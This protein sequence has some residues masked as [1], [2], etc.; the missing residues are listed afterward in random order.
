[1]QLGISITSAHPDADPAEGARRIIERARAA[2]AAELDSLSLGDH[3]ATAYPYFQGTPMLGR[4][5]ADWPADRPMGCLFLLPLWNPVLVAEQVGTLAALSDRPFV[6]QTGIGGGDQQFA[7][8]GSSPA[9]RGRD[10]DEAIRV[11]KALSAGETVT[12]ERFG[13]TDAVTAPRPPHGLEWWIGAGAPAAI[14]RAAREGDAWYAGPGV[15]AE[16]GAGMLDTYR[17]AC[18]RHD[19][20]PRAI[21]R[22]DLIVLDDGDRAARLG[23][24]LIASG[25]RGMQR[26]EVVCG[27]VDHVS[28]E[29][30]RLRSLG[31]DQV[32]IR[33]M[34]GIT[35][36]EAIETIERCGEVR[37]ALG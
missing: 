19:R 18:E 1:M 26:H 34:M 36:A 16:V 7:A 13:F 14:E 8:M 5:A 4:L 24:E 25:Y 9:R 6:V 10:L 27:G 15:T 33:T 2:T 11:I 35:Q 20:T 22:K 17:E 28:E 21:V 29:F 30:A 12:S 3:H 31:F 23:D 32:V 37:R